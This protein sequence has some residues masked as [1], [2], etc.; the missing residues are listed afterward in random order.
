[1][2]SEYI[3]NML[4]GP[5][6]SIPLQ[7]RRSRWHQIC[8]DRSSPCVGSLLELRLPNAIRLGKPSNCKALRTAF[9]AVRS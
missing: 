2:E 8:R 6:A 1:M 7:V 5:N 3:V 9:W 4:S